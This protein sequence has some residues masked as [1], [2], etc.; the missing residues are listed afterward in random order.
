M[1]FLTEEYIFVGLQAKALW[2]WNIQGLL[3]DRL[4]NL[5]VGE[6]LPQTHRPVVSVH[7]VFL[8]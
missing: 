2:Y 4:Q 1:S 7:Y 8:T 6:A 5:V 3:T